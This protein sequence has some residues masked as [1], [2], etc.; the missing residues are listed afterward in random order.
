M[1]NSAQTDLSRRSTI[2]QIVRSPVALWSAFILTH[3]WLG[4]VNLYGPGWPLGDVNSVYKYWA[5]LVSVSH[6]IVGIDGG[7]VYPIFAIVP[8][9]IAMVFGL[10]VYSSTWLSLVMLLNAVAFAFIIGWTPGKNRGER[11][12]GLRNHLVG[13]WWI[14]YLLLLGPIALGRIDSISVPLAIVGIMFIAT[15]PALAAVIL[16]IAAWIKVWPAAIVA[17]IVIAS[18]ARRQVLVAAVVTSLTI[19]VIAVILGSGLNVFSFVTQQTSRG[20][21]IEA[22]V[23]SIWLWQALAGTPGTYL[24]Y[25]QAL[26]T[27]QIVGTGAGVV[28][29]LMTP[30]MALAAIAIALIAIRAMR[31]GATATQVL[32]PLTLA[33]VTAL[34]A[35]NKVGSPQFMSWLAV[36]IILGLAMNLAGYRA[37]F[38]APAVMVL[39]LG[40]LTQTFY[41]YL[42]GY[43][44]NLD[45]IIVVVLTARNL[46][47]FV[48]L[49]WAIMALW[50][51]TARTEIT[52]AEITQAE[53]AVN[54]E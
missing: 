54:E 48:L 43:L 36:P 46:L 18:R 45:P 38:R 13:W 21:Q 49:G 28:G 25:D 30:L 39:I 42:Y 26:M 11:L 10:A 19:I 22:P 9:L 4:V 7:W 32:A 6:Y 34:I 40:A 52:Q 12:N 1:K 51:V 37:S 31:A 35:F 24:Y 8:M 14:A 47:V 5:E 27:Y 16:T 3:L 50:R 44:L 15:R 33:L 29:S 41:P 2:G 20:L 53:Y 17:A 23:S